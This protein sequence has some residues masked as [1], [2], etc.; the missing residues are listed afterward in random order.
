MT[1]QHNSGYKAIHCAT[2]NLKQITAQNSSVTLLYR[3]VSSCLE[4]QAPDGWLEHDCLAEISESS[5]LH[6]D[7]SQH[8]LEGVVHKFVSCYKPDENTKI[9]ILCGY[10][11]CPMP[12]IVDEPHSIRFPQTRDKDGL[13]CCPQGCIALCSSVLPFL[14]YH[15]KSQSD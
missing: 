2:E 9:I 14:M 11:G 4:E 5:S 13:I 6:T 1:T 7:L 15:K 12:N 8:L 3:L 10:S